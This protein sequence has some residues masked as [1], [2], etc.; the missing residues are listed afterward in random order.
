MLVS[1]TSKEVDHHNLQNSKR[2]EMA[3]EN[4]S[5]LH[6]TKSD[7]TRSS[8]CESRLSVEDMDKNKITC[9]K[10]S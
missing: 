6:E 9:I 7:I 3:K 10:N 1:E 5:C 4:E 8:S 2:S